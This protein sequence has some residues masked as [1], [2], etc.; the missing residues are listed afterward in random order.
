[1]PD[2]TSERAETTLLERALAFQKA[3]HAALAAELCRQVLALNPDRAEA[4]LMLGLILGRTDDPAAGAGLIERY[5]ALNP[6]DPVAGYNL[7]LLRQRQGHDAAALAL[8]ERVLA[9]APDLAPAHHALGVTLHALDRLDDAAAAFERALALEPRDAVALNNL[10]DLRRNQGRLDDALAAFDRALAQ[11][12]DLAIA[13]CNRGV[14]LAELKRHDDAIAAFEQ[15]LALDPALTRAHF[16]LAESLEESFQP[17]AAHAH[18][19][20]AV[21]RHPLATT[22]CTTA[23]PTARIL[24]LCSAGRGDVSV[25]FLLDRTRFEKTL[26]FLLLPAD[27]T[28]DYARR[29]AALPPVDLV[30]NAIADADRGA[31]YLAQA[32]AL[33][34]AQERPVLNPPAAIAKTRRDRAGALLAGIPGLIAPPTRRLSR[35][36][37]AARAADP[38]PFTEPQLVRPAGSHGGTGL[39]RIEQPAELAAYLARVTDDDAFYLSDFCDYRSADGYCRKYRFA[40]VDRV[41][42][43]YHLAITRHWRVHYWRADMDEAPWMKAE[44]ERFLADPASVFDGARGDAIREI[45][46]RLDLDYA[47]VDC[48][49]L[50]DG[51]VVVFE[52]NANILV[53][54][55]DPLD[56]FAYKHRYVPR[57]FAAMT[58]LVRRRLGAS[59]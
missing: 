8:L 34:A 24:V 49:V 56:G 55:N 6:D 26:L 3:G 2:E 15:A 9:R 13:H 35:A 22:P 54:L 44:E 45:G 29:T 53:H 42:L 58:E 27:A 57:I 30:F 39:E 50:P 46:R 10:G 47:G 1:M 52:A 20:A 19:V 11:R 59:G 36:A 7:A 4:L 38:A 43:P 21:R 32:A 18:R 37:L 48:G 31:P 16:E 28:D 12:P 23:T 17:A 40:F 33:C 5:L 51:R 14:V 41:P 25:K